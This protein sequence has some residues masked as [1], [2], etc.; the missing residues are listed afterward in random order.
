MN[1][2]DTT[3]FPHHQPIRA[4]CASW[5]HTWKVPSSPCLCKWLVDTLRGFP[6]V[7]DSKESACNADLGFDSWVG[8]IPFRREWQPTPVFLPGEF[9]EQRSVVGYSPWGHKESDKIEDLTQHTHTIG[10]SGVFKHKSVTL[11]VLEHLQE[12]CT[13]PQLSVSRLPLPC[14]SEWTQVWLRNKTTRTSDLATMEQLLWVSK[15]RDIT[16]LSSS[17]FSKYN[18]FGFICSQSE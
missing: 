3:L 16:I 7:S 15:S 11:L 1:S 6:G 5:P 9:H 13:L 2:R 8:K 10:E 18:I 14:K 17:T 12:S 4:L